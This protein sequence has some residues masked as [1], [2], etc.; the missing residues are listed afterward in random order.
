MAGFVVGDVVIV[1]F[2]LAWFK[3]GI[4]KVTGHD[5]FDHHCH[6]DQNEN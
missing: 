4:F 6:D 1:P 2:P 3:K 5:K